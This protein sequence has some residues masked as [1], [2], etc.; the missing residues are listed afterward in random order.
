M[1]S[2]LNGFSIR[3]IEPTHDYIRHH[4]TGPKD[5]W[6]R[7]PGDPGPAQNNAP[8]AHASLPDA[9]DSPPGTGPAT[10]VDAAKDD[11]WVPAAGM[12]AAP[13][14]HLHVH[15][16]FS[17]LDG[18]SRI[19]ELV[20]RAAQLGQPALALTDH[21]GLYGI[22]RF[23]KACTRHG[24]KPIYGAEV[25]VESFLAAGSPCTGDRPKVPAAPSPTDAPPFS[26]PNGPVGPGPF[27]LVLLAETRQGY[28]NL[29]RLVSAAHLADPERHSPPTVSQAALEQ[30]HA[31]LICLTGCRQGEVGTL[32]DAGRD[33]EATIV[34]R[35][36][37]RLFGPSNVFVELQHFG[38]QPHHEAEPGRGGVTIYQKIRGD[39][40][41]LRH[42]AGAACTAAVTR[43]RP[44]VR[45]PLP[46]HKSVYARH[47]VLTDRPDLPRGHPQYLNPADYDVGFHPDGRPW[48]LS[49]DAY[50][51]HLLALARRAGLAA[52]L[53]TDAHY[54]TPL[55][56]DLHL[57]CR[58]AGR[59]QPLSGYPE[60]LPGCRCLLSRE[61]LEPSLRPVLLLH[62]MYSA[63]EVAHSIAPA[64]AAGGNGAAV[65]GMGSAAD[66]ATPPQAS[67]PPGI[68]YTGPS[69]LDTPALIA[70]RCTV[71]LDLGAYHFPQ[72]PIARGETAYS[73]LAKRCFRG[74]ARMYRPVPPRAVQLLEKELAMIE[75]MGFAHYFLVVHDIVRWAR[76]R[77]IFCSGRGSAGNS[78]VCYA[79]D[80]TASEPIRHNLLFERFL[81]PHRREMPDID[82]DFCSERRDEV[83]DYIYRTFGQEN[84]AVVA[85]VNTMSPRLAVRTVAEALGYAPTEINALAKHVPRHGDAARIREYLAGAWPELRDS[86]LQ[87]SAPPVVAPDGT[88]VTPGGRYCRL[89]DLVERLD[90]FPMHLGTHLGGFVIADRPIT[91]Y[92]PLQ[93]AAKGVVVTQFNKDDVAALGL[94][95]MDILGLRTHSAV[96]ETVHLIRQRT[97]RRLRPYQLAPQDPAAY[98]IVSNGGSIGLF[99]LESAGQ[100]NLAT[101]L[102]EQ[103]F[104]DVIAA[105][106]LYRPGPL[107]AEMIG[108]FID[109]RWGVEPVTLPHPAM[110]EALADTYGVILYQEQVLRMAQS[111]AGFDPAEADML[112]RAMTRDRT[113]EEMARIGETFVA[114]SVAN[115]VP[116]DAAREVFRQLEGFA[117]YGF[118]KSHSVC[119]AVIAYAT[120]YLKAH[121]PAEFLCAVLNN[122]PMG[123]YTPRT[124]LNDARRF[125]LE[126]RPLDVNLS[127]RGF[128][129]E[130]A[131]PPDPWA[132]YAA[133]GVMGVS[134][135]GE[136]GAGSEGDEP[137]PEVTGAAGATVASAEAAAQDTAPPSGL[138]AE[139]QTPAEPAKSTQY[140]DAISIYSVQFGE[141]ATRASHPQPY[142]PFAF[143]WTEERHWGLTHEDLDELW[144]EQNGEGALTEA[145]SREWKAAVE[146]AAVGAAVPDEALVRGA[147]GQVEP[148]HAGD[149]EQDGDDAHNRSRIAQEEHADRRRP[150]RPDAGPDRV[151]R[152]HGQRLQRQVEEHEAANGEEDKDDGWY[153]ATEPVAQLER[154]GKA[155]LE[156]PCSD[157]QH[158]GHGD[159]PADENPA[160]DSFYHTPHAAGRA[161]VGRDGASG[162]GSASSHPGDHPLTPRPQPGDLILPRAPRARGGVAPGTCLCPEGA[163]EP[164]AGRAVRVGFS[165]LKQMSER[166]L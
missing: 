133:A 73:L 149:D 72:V 48:A 144:Q 68:G 90:A 21:D 5:G 85:N 122:Q 67:P 29:C 60:P 166:A 41:R 151:G 143:A 10:G 3:R 157:E 37:R 158:P 20:T 27:H 44:Q 54:A 78:I 75:R 136:T 97:G 125:G 160:T 139:V 12:P 63:S 35:H 82:V 128:T 145:L 92:A 138:A 137:P 50:C 19:E 65:S 66:G 15:S 17:F 98:E 127:G 69:P 124:V 4:G 42:N 120:A 159:L 111:V 102:K 57:V 146:G 156:Q 123:F 154:H 162:R 33:A 62:K 104:D 115:G 117:A 52:V 163:L 1:T 107:E 99:Q 142:D 76:E 36:L 61:E 14:V 30:H 134:E 83:I 152:A 140:V 108:P 38:Y 121:Y 84:V 88:V 6:A 47:I 164:G 55:D 103:T 40:G 113:R 105:I 53:T 130:D 126:V 135:A 118:N 148:H 9:D 59:D 110:A 94:V 45:Q 56:R 80:I 32:V 161:G 114:K 131:L 24:I 91:H 22:V 96:A 71:D 150:C 77:G 119:F 93:W 74:L 11:R 23:T 2:G 64:N 129:V 26:T 87:D 43:P 46:L 147:P 39:D 58:A 109:R 106:A 116:A 31:G 16:H 100:R 81:N 8:P 132:G 25:Q 49:C 86:P 34:L 7:G 95:K 13:F 141:F 89:L 18:G 101:R 165:Q 112:R 155:D 28:A 79:L 51:D 153:Q 70:A